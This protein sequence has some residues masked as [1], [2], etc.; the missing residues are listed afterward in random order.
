MLRQERI[1]HHFRGVAQQEQ[2]AAQR[3]A[4][5]GQG[6]AMQQSNG[7]PCQSPS[8]FPNQ[9]QG[10]QQPGPVSGGMGN[11]QG[12]AMPMPAN[13]MGNSMAHHLRVQNQQ[14]LAPVDQGVPL[15]VHGPTPV[16]APTAGTG[17]APAVPP[18][19]RAFPAEGTNFT[20]NDWLGGLDLNESLRLA[21]VSW[22]SAEQLRMLSHPSFWV[23]P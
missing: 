10:F 4:L 11:S 19:P 17:H 20:N 16:L 2:Q 23:E 5:Q 9:T 1:A 6:L 15:T 14:T 7:L 18:L 22:A 8:M 21:W 13:A 3:Q 12:Y